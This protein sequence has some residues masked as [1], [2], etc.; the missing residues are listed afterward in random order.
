MKRHD[1]AFFADQS[2][3]STIA[4]WCRCCFEP[5]AEELSR[6]VRRR[7]RRAAS[8]KPRPAPASS[9]RPC[10]SPCPTRKSSR[11]TSTSRCSTWPR[12]GSR[13]AQRHASTQAD[14]L[15]LPFDD[16]T[17]DLVVCQFGV[18]FFPDKVR[19]NAEARRVLRDGGHYL[20]AI[21]DD[22]AQSAH[23]G[24]QQMPSPP[25]S[26]RS[27]RFHERMPFRYHDPTRSRRTSRCG[28]RRRSRSRRSSCAAAAASARDAAAALLLRHADA[29]RDGGMRP[30]SARPRVRDAASSAAAV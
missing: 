12:G 4:T 25:F 24:R 5:Y 13:S 2:R 9:P 20:L 11:P 29:A 14:A 3:R 1:F 15:E 16:E 27:R 22:R 19:G 30:D 28:I 18:M 10:T 26:G 7:C 8:S 23:R 21:W 17:F 6:R